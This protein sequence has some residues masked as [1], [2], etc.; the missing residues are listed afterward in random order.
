M[1]RKA[2]LIRELIRATKVS[3]QRKTE[4]EHD[5]LKRIALAVSELPDNL[6][7]SLSPK[8]ET[9]YRAAVESINAGRMITSLAAPNDTSESGERPKQNQESEDVAERP[10]EEAA[11]QTASRQ[12]QLAKVPSASDRARRIILENLG[13]V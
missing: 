6:R 2:S 8:A 9:W 12:A 4:S 3:R 10:V 7:A 13:K 5:H 1:P 11:T